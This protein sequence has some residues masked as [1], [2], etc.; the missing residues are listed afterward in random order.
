VE[1]PIEKNPKQSPKKLESTKDTR[2]LLKNFA[3]TRKAIVAGKGNSGKPPKQTA[4]IATSFKLLR[5]GWG[6]A[7]G[8][9]FTPIERRTS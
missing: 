7:F 6:C 4:A 2:E 8:K 3:L 5:F 1:E 9:E